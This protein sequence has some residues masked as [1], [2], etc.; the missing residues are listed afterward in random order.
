M[1]NTEIAGATIIDV[2]YPPPRHPDNRTSM[3]AERPRY[4][5]CNSRITRP[6]NIYFSIARFLTS[7]F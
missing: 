4:I 3:S 5:T 2:H 6:G 7:E 1:K